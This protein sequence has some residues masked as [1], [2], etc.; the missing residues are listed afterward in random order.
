MKMEETNFKE[1]SPTRIGL[2]KY[3]FQGIVSFLVIAASLLFFFLLFRMDTLQGIFRKIASILQPVTLGLVIAYLLNPIVV[4]FEKNLTKL[5]SSY[6]NKREKIRSFLRYVSIFIALI[7]ASIAVYILGSLIIPEVYVSIVGIIK[8]LPDNVNEFTKWVQNLTISNDLAADYLDKIIIKGTAYVEEW[9]QGDL[10]KQLN[11]WAGYFATGVLSVINVFKNLLIGLIIS[12][13]V[14]ASKEK[15]S[16]QGKMIIY[17]LSKHSAANVIIDTVRQSNQIFSGFIVGKLIDSTIIGFLCFFGL[18]CLNMP[19]TLLVSVIVGVTN[20][21][22]FFGPYIG[23][24]PSTLLILVVSPIHALYFIIFIVVLQQIDGNIIG[25]KI[26]GESTGLSAFWVVFSILLGGGLFGL[27]GMLVGV[28]TFAVIYFIVG[29]I[30]SHLLEKKNLKSTSEE[31]E[32]IESIQICDGEI[33]YVSL[34]SQDTSPLK[35]NH[36][37]E[38]PFPKE[39][40]KKLP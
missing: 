29:R 3:L 28:P 23:A 22:P 15:F 13:Y 25:P 31:Y 18:S 7:I 16:A 27:V 24:I 35:K 1:D 37:K 9:A 38:E 11:T 26:L 10:L 5:L 20:V 40:K 14:L 6:I 17:A 19:Y 8:E 30:I 33:I 21:I 36:K 34:D 12:V 2:K 4:F 39:E 32:K